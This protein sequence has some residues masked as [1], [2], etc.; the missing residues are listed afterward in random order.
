MADIAALAQS[1]LPPAALV[2][3]GPIASLQGPLYP[4]E[5]AAI[6]R[7]RAARRAEFTAGRTAARAALAQ[8]GLPPLP[9]PRAPLGPVIW[10][11]GVTGSITHGAGHAL[12][13]VGPVAAFAGLGI[14]IETAGSLLPLADIAAPGEIA[15][16]QGRDPVILFSAKESAFKAL[17]AQTGQLSGFRDLTVT[18]DGARFVARTA[19]GDSI[20]GR[21]LCRNGIVLTA[22]TRPAAS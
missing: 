21:W 10:P 4:V 2:T 22:A 11:D 17:F 7:A 18:L 9:L 13:V 16:L 5:A 19:G 6:T 8:L 14:D 3:G 15:A 1:L 20:P 12:A